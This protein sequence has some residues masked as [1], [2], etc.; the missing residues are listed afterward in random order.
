MT[1]ELRRHVDK[2]MRIWN[3]VRD[4]PGEMRKP[5]SIGARGLTAIDPMFL[6]MKATEQWG[7]MGEGWGFD[8]VKDAFVNQNGKPEHVLHIMEI[9]LWYTLK[10]GEDV[11]RMTATEVINRRRGKCYTTGVGCTKV[12]MGT[13]SSTHGMWVDDEFNKKTLTDALTNALSRLGFGAD[14]RMGK[15]EGGKYNDLMSDESAALARAWEKYI[16]WRREAKGLDDKITDM[17]IANSAME[18]LKKNSRLVNPETIAALM[19]E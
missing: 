2:N 17:E 18:Y 14:V 6:F 16:P 7:S 12:F 8:I 19:E 13:P 10:F 9:K 3:E 11:D 1:D 5:F 15:F 4:V